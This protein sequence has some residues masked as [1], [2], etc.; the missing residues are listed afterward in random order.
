MLAWQS[1]FCEPW[2][3]F[4]LLSYF[5][6][7]SAKRLDGQNLPRLPREGV[8]SEW[9]HPRFPLKTTLNVKHSRTF[10]TPKIITMMRM[11]MMM[12]RRRRRRTTASNNNGLQLKQ[13]W[14]VL[15]T[16]QR[17]LNSGKHS[18]VGLCRVAC[19]MCEFGCTYVCT[20]VKVLIHAGTVD[21]YETGTLEHLLSCWAKPH[22][23]APVC[24]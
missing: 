13:R 18:L 14:P 23:Y 21:A 12:R 11:M 17:V 20:C 10:M 7:L 4:R 24:A 2:N 3:L 15:N 16:R 22:M 1:Q 6:R 19:S 5:M 9:G 8:L